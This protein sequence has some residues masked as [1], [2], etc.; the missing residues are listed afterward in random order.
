M[1]STCISALIRTCTPRIPLA[2]EN[3]AEDI[4]EIELEVGPKP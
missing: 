3:I 4:A 1:K 2:G